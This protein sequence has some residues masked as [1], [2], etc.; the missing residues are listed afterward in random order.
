MRII[1]MLY[2]INLSSSPHALT[3][4]DTQYYVPDMLKKYSITTY[5]TIK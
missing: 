1:K 5:L 4:S 2:K 3:D